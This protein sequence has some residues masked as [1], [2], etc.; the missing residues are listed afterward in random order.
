MLHISLTFLTFFSV[1][2][3]ESVRFPSAAFIA[4]PPSVPCLVPGNTVPDSDE[5][6]VIDSAQVLTESAALENYFQ[7]GF[8]Q[9]IDEV[10]GEDG[11]EEQEE[12]ADD[13]DEIQAVDNPRTRPALAWADKFIFE[14]RRKGGR[15]T[16]N[17]VLKLWKVCQKL[18]QQFFRVA[19]IAS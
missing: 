16:E 8:R 2:G 7:Q 1:P 14:T 5:A 13:D 19:I 9:E 12:V 10:E 3:P 15:Q 4:S 17:S 18:S 11:E 6:L